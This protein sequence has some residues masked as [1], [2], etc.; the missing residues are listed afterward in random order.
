MCAK[1]LTDKQKKKIIADYVQLGSYAATA[2]LNR[3]SDN[4]V[5]KLV[6]E[7]PEI[8]R[9]CE[10][11]KEQNAKDML[12]YMES[13]SEEA[14]NLLGLYLKAMADPEKIEAATLP[15]LST[16]F[17]TIVDKFAMLGDHGAEDVPDDGLI[18]ALNMAADI[19]PP[20]DVAL[21]PE[22]STDDTE[23]R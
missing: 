16:A 2:R 7:N 11:K 9:K 4:T 8:A 21:L 23:K 13:K 17:G 20:D 15:Q 6:A 22:E 12:S 1:R 3:I 10:Q 18:D 19:S 5:R 14:Q